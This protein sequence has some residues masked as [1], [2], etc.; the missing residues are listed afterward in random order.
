[1]KT[2]KCSLIFNVE[3]K[4]NLDTEKIT[5]TTGTTF[6]GTEIHYFSTNLGYY[7]PAELINKFGSYSVKYN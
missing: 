4:T 1:M 2:I 3:Q 5:E 7:T 6:S